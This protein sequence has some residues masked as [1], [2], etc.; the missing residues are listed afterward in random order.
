MPAYF[1]RSILFLCSY[2]PLVAIYCILLWGTWPLWAVLLL[3]SAG[4]ASL[5][6]TALIFHRLRH[7][8]VAYRRKVVSVTRRNGDVMAYV[9]SYIFPFVSFSLA[10]VQQAL[11]LGVFF[12]VLF[13]IY[14]HSNMIY[15]NPMLNMLGYHLYEV[16]L[17]G[18]AGSRMYI[19]RGR[20]VRGDEIQFVALDNDICLQT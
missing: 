7:D 20:L 1:A 19:A 4:L 6:L 14:V 3:L 15:V 12:V 10:N 16:E 9:A 17:D 11:A 8:N 5:L 13:F 2:F 18:S